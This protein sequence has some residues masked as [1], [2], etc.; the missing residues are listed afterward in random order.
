MEKQWKQKRT[1]GTVT[2]HYRM[3]Q[4]GKKLLQIN[5]I[6]FCLEFAHRG[7]LDGNKFDKFSSILEKIC[8][9]C[10]GGSMTKDLAI[11]FIKQI[12]KY[13]SIFNKIDGSLRRN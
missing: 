3:H 7:E 2:R 11:W 8:I 12:F 13:K 6:D 4:E 1:H 10:V 9:D 5:R